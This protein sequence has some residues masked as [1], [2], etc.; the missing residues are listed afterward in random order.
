MTKQ[1]AVPAGAP[2]LRIGTAVVPA[3]TR[4]PIVHAM[5]AMTL[6][7]LTGAN[8]ILGVGLSSPNIVRDWAGQPFNR[9]LTRMRE[10]I[11]IVP[12][13]QADALRGRRRG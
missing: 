5:A 6:S 8:F 13:G 10:H 4:T 1:A 9:P 2:G 11:D 12:T 7:Q 3:Q